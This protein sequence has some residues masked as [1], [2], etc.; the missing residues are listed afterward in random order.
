MIRKIFEPKINK[1]F[2][3]LDGVLANFDKFVLDNLGR[4]FNH[5]SGPGA[6]KEMW[7]FLSTV[8][9]LYL[10]LEPTPYAKQLWDLA[11]S[12]DSA[13][14]EILTAIPRRTSIPEAEENKR[15][16]VKKFLDPNATFNIGP[17]SKD[18][19]R[20]AGFGDILVDDRESNVGDWIN[21]GCGIGIL[22]DL[23]D[24]PSTAQR[25]IA[26]ATEKI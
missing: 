20:H 1:I 11:N 8:K 5:A 25:L 19:W 13:G 15:E 23:N 21:K 6:D 4:T 17:Y 22:H 2:L 16:W 3:D 9:D 14:V 10:N 24:Y 12:L 7:D 26:F 18:K